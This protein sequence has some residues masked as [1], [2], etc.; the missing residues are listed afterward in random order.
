MKPSRRISF[1]RWCA[2]L[3]TVLLA[4]AAP[5]QS[6]F[7]L[8]EQVITGGGVTLSRGAGFTL[9]GTLGQPVARASRGGSFVLAGGFWGAAIAVQ[10][11]GMP[12]LRVTRAQ[13]QITVSWEFGDNDAEIIL[14]E[15]ASLGVGAEWSTV[16][17]RRE[18]AGGE[19]RI[20]WPANLS[21]RF[22]RLRRPDLI[23]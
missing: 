23:P 1:A 17:L 3:T 21:N 7:A 11:A 9:A 2:G 18:V 6:N 12:L 22:F 20:Q 5:A 15:S 4:Y 19:V 14:E 13:S 16:V 10:Q 8:L